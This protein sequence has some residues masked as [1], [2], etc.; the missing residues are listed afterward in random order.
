MSLLRSAARAWWTG[1]RFW[2]PPHFVRR[3]FLAVWALIGIG[4]A[5]ALPWIARQSPCAV[6]LIA[7]GALLGA[8]FLNYAF[9]R[10]GED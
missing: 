4:S 8:G 3:E 6:A 9:S 2:N 7:A 10:A 5:V 1:I